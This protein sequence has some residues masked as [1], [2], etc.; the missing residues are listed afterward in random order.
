MFF[1]IFFDNF[2]KL[3][4]VLLENFYDTVI[5]SSDKNDRSKLGT[6]IFTIGD[7]VKQHIIDGIKRVIYEVNKDTN[8][9]ITPIN[10]PSNL[11]LVIPPSRSDIPYYLDNTNNIKYYNIKNIGSLESNSGN[12]SLEN[13]FPKNF[14]E[15]ERNIDNN[16]IE[17]QESLGCGRHA[18]NNLLGNKYFTKEY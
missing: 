14:D 10:I 3:K 9:N 12:Q 2:F 5:Y 4:T 16:F 17:A 18:L 7:E 6:N 15:L 1:A 8:R 13:Q 11:K